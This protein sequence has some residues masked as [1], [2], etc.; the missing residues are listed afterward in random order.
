MK[1]RGIIKANQEQGY[2]ALT[3]VLIV[4]AVVLVVALG[5]SFLSMSES[6]MAF[7]HSQSSAS[8][9]LANACAEEALLNL[10][11]NPSYQPSQPH[12]T[13]NFTDGS[14]RIL[15]PIQGNGNR[16]RIIDVSG[17]I[18]N[19]IRKLK[20]KVLEISPNTIIRSWQ[21]VAEF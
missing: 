4:L 8:Y 3:T 19:K 13:L 18:A 5:A 21:E 2:I 11:N 7:L 6:D 20:I 12:E 14:C 15:Y 9:Y 1:K 17:E 10:K 16:Y